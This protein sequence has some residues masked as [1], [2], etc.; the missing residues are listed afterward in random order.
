[1]VPLRV[2]PC[3]GDPPAVVDR[4]ALWTGQ[5]PGGLKAAVGPVT[6]GLVAACIALP[7]LTARSVSYDEGVSAAMATARWPSFVGTA[8]GGEA[9]MSLYYLLLRWLPA[10]HPTAAVLR[11]PSAAAF[12]V[13]V[14][15]VTVAGAQ[16]MGR[17]AG[18]LGAALVATNAHVVNSA[19]TARSYALLMAMSIASTVLLLRAG[20]TRGRDGSAWVLGWG[21][22]SGLTAYVHLLGVV[23]TA[24]QVVAVGLAWPRRLRSLLVGLVAAALLWAPLGVVALRQGTTSISWIKKPSLEDLG[25]V[26]AEVAGGAGP[27]IVIAAASI[28]ALAT[29]SVAREP[30]VRFLLAMTL[31]PLVGVYLASL[32]GPTPLLLPRYLIGVAPAGALLVGVAV[33][34]AS[35]PVVVAGLAVVAVTG[36]L[37]GLAARDTSSGEDF[38]A[39]AALVSQQARVGDV[40]AFVDPTAAAAFTVYAG[41][42]APPSVFP[43]IAPGESLYDKRRGLGY[44]GEEIPDAVRRAARAHSRVWV[45]ESHTT[46]EWAAALDGRLLAG[47]ANVGYTRHDSCSFAGVRVLLYTAISQVQS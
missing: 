20:K 41:A 2:V 43:E 25:S 7:G 24:T 14:P 35:R 44:I 10:V 9:N 8:I 5:H 23:T 38:R 6:I 19:Q 42:G 1:M 12:I 15:L 34:H 45:I 31:V 40:S 27:L 37:H 32:L 11:A 3:P 28:W 33:T 30:A 17:A 29:K 4:R 36:N 39:A 21:V 47:L 13:A 26:T 18:L 46:T 22:V 16:L